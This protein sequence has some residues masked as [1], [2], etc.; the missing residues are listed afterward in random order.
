MVEITIRQVEPRDIDA[1]HVI[2][3]QRSVAAGTAQVL[4]TSK[5]DRRGWPPP[6]SHFRL[7]VAEVDDQVVGTAGLEIFEGRR[8]HVGAIGMGVDERFHGQGVGKAM[9]AALVDLADNWYG[10]YRIELEV[11]T[12]NAVAVHLYQRF[13]FEIEGTLRALMYRE[14]A[15]AD[16]Y[17]MARIRRDSA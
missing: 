5:A 1:F 7:L 12:D 2:Y 13:G 10:L 16:A 15:Y 6:S 14:G 3:N 4:Y 17:A 11:Y 8:A 9:M